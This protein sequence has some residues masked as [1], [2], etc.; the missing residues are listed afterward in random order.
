M[1][2][3]NSLKLVKKTLAASC[4]LVFL[5]SFLPSQEVNAASNAGTVLVCTQPGA[6]VQEA[7]NALTKTGCV[8]LSEVPCVSGNFTVLHVRPTNGNVAAT[9]SSINAQLDPNIGTAETNFQTKTQFFDCGG[10]QRPTC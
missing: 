1:L 3:A 8:I 6:D 5:N 4:S 2:N 10:W 9:V 7:R